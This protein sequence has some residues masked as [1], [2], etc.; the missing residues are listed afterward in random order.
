MDFLKRNLAPLTDEAWEEIESR[1]KEVFET[2]LSA[3]KVVHVEGPKGPDYTA[4]TQ[5]RLTNIEG[6]KGEVCTGIYEVKPLVE[7]RIT[8]ELSRWEMDNVVRG[9]KD[10]DLSPLEDAVKKAALFE[11]NALYNGHVSSGIKGLQNITTNEIIPFGNNGLDIMESIA[12]ATLVLKEAFTEKPYTLVVSKEA[13][14]R[15][16]REVQGYPLSKR[17]EALLGGG[18]VYSDV[19]EGALLLPYNHDDIEMTI[20][21]DFSIGYESSNKEN[22]Q[23]FITESFTFRVLD[24]AL[25]VKFSI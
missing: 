17:I 2:Q 9:A 20:G 5:G 8:F 24:P 13:W 19:I 1:A 21:R 6:E 25:I 16:N 22:V 12:Q 14:K 3:R 11:E 18:I 10:I 4:L 7:T 23:L 15:I